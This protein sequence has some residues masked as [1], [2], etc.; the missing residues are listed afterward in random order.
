M[1]DISVRGL[2]GGIISINVWS[3]F[4]AYVVGDWLI[5]IGELAIFA[6]L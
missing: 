3:R 2:L 5:A 6:T 4:I 1:L